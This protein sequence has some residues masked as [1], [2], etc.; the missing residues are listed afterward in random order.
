MDDSKLDTLRDLK[1]F[2]PKFLTIRTK[3]GAPMPFELN[4]AQEY[5]HRRI[6]HQR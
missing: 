5:I 1:K 6:E 2:A 3:S 4:R